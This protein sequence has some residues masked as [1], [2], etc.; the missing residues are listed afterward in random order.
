ME[1]FVNL[2]KEYKKFSKK[3]EEFNNLINNLKELENKNDFK[4]F[5]KIEDNLKTYNFE[6]EDELEFKEI[7][8]LKLNKFIEKLKIENLNKISELKSDLKLNKFH[9]K[10][11]FNLYIKNLNFIENKELQEINDI[12]EK[13]E[14]K[15]KK[16]LEL[17][18]NIED[19]SYEDLEKLYLKPI[20]FEIY[21]N[22]DRI[23]KIRINNKKEE[24]KILMKDFKGE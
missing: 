21:F 16:E 18:E 20:D 4:I 23:R 9:S 14:L 5:K 2:E 8:I 15:S 11:E 10:E 1:Y 7:I 3:K 6:Y 13:N 24:I 19:L 12:I 17:Y 22:E